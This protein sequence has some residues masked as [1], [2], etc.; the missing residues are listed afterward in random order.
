MR[1]Y[2]ENQVSRKSYQNQDTL[3][4]ALFQTPHFID[5]ETALQ[6]GEVTC[7]ML[8]NWLEKSLGTG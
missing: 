3:E 8:G 6:R 1:Q 2:F 7:L 5:V 4:K